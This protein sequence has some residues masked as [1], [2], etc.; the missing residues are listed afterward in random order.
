MKKILKYI[1]SVD[2][3]ST[4][5]T[6]VYFCGIK[7]RHLKASVKNAKENYIKWE[8]AVSE[9]P[10][11]TGVLRKI[12][13]ADL[14]LMEIFD[15]LCKENNLG[16]WLDF[17][18]LL[19]AVRHKGFIPWD[20]DV[21]LGMI[22]DDY[23]KFI[24]LYKDG[25]PQYPDLYLQFN[26]NGKNKCFVKVL[27]KKLPSVQID[28]F[29]Y[30]FYY[31]KTNTEEKAEL[32][33]FIKSIVN[34]RIYKL[35]FLFFLNRPQAMRKRFAKLRDKE[36][37]KGNKVIKEEHPSLFYGIDYPHSHKQ[38]V[39]DYDTIFPLKTINFDGKQFLCPN[40]EDKLLTDEFGNYMELPDDCYPRHANSEVLPKEIE[41][42]IEKFLQIGAEK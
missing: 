34:R 9:I 18:N 6:I 10:K 12:Q 32:T 41:E 23:E 8:G 26:N 28:I 24:E 42:E 2:T 40:N 1:F 7:F 31:K 16:Y 11:A 19:G 27:H 39:F 20:D 3:T 38:L 35:I 25:I 33:K 22:R 4:N 36:I 17:G 30:D 21:D 37:L 29:P 14:K 13:L 15:K 5:R